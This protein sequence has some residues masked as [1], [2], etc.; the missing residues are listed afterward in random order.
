MRATAKDLR[1]RTRECLE[2][3]SR[4]EDVIITHRGRPRAKLVP[5]TE[6]TSTAANPLLGIWSDDKR[7]RDVAS[8]V[9]ALR[10]RRRNAG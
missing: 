2:A 4:G 3:T 8:Y 10:Q 5:I 1:F 9:R 7:S 6:R